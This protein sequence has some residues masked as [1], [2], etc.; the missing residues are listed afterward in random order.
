MAR[1]GSIL[2]VSDMQLL[3]WISAGF[4]V[5]VLLGYPLLLKAFVPRARRGIQKRPQLRPVTV[6]IAVHN[7][8]PWIRNKLASVLDSDYPRDLMQLLVVSDGSLD[9][10][11]EL[12]EEFAADGVE[13]IRVPRGG[14]ARAVNAGLE[15]ATGEIV[16]FT[17]ARQPLH[18]ACIRNL[19]ASLADPEVGAVSA[20]LVTL[21]G[22]SQEEAALGLYW[23]YDVW[24]RR[25]LSSLHS[26][27]GTNGP[28]YA[29]RRDLT[30][31]LPPDVILDDVYLPLAAYFRG[32]RIVLD[33]EARCFDYPMPLGVELGRKVRTLAGL[34]QIL[35][36]YPAL[37]LP[38][39]PM[40]IHFLSYK[41]LR[42]LLPYALLAMAVA[43]FFLPRWW[44][45]AALCA[46]LGLYGLAAIDP[47]IGDAAAVKR[48]SSPARTFLG[49]MIAAAQ[50]VQIFFIPPRKIWKVTAIAPRAG[51]GGR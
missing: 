29:M 3:F 33:E 15:R 23:R 1:A 48:L 11:E 46:Q 31:P 39:H 17:D 50:A 8:E 10:T 38:R 41:F 30:V 26:T 37:L 13:L 14:K 36:Y 7:G 24:I 44:L 51:P 49:L 35:R 40:W 2:T 25:R 45:A 22:D 9:R 43:T 20:E 5:Y 19:A 4:V 16:V 42:L 27:F 12:V 6:L 18:P 34:Y 32:H 47:W 28:C 21:K